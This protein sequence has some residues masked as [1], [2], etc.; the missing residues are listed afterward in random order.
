MYVGGEVEGVLVEGFIDLLYASPAGLVIVDYKTDS[1]R[2]MASI[3]RAMT[4]YRL[5]GAAYALVLEKALGRPV[6]GC[7]FVFTEPRIDVQV[8]DLGGAKEEVRE[9]LRRRLTP[10]AVALPG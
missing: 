4:R 9:L 5:Q 6:A 3:E 2:D 1:A 8:D 7:V 10:R